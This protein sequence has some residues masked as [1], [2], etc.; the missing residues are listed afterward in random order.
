MTIEENIA[1]AKVDNIRSGLTID[2]AK[3]GKLCDR[4]VGDLEIKIASNQQKVKSLSGGNQQK[5]MIGKW[6]ATNPQLLIMDEP[7]RGIDVGAKSEIHKMLRKLANEGIG[8]IIISSELP[9]IIGV[10][11][12]V[13][14]MHEG[15]ISGELS[16]SD[17]SEENIIVYA[18]G[19]QQKT[20][21]S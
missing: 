8:V 9:E 10:A 16:G 1:A 19:A 13:V 5:V 21:A 15:K 3:Q 2:K 11:D 6:L 20:A 17:L 18:S 7:T 14:V 4:Y 12:R